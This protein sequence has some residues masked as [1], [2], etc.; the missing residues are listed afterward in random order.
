MR[1]TESVVTPGESGGDV[2]IE[3][4]R[5]WLRPL[6]PRDLDFF[7]ELHSDPEITRFVPTFTREQARERLAEIGRQWSERGHGLC[8]VQ[9]KETGELIGRCGLNHWEL[10]DEVE[11]GWTFRR[12]C[13][14]RGYATEAARAVV[15]WGFDRLDVDYFTAMIVHGNSASVRVAER[16]GFEPGRQ[17]T[18][19]GKPVTVHMLHRPGRHRARDADR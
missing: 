16:L 14:G 6:T 3:T 13:W 4:E 15:E 12:D 7:V 17:D 5:L 9:S 2:V 19:L 10:F 1:S 8:A 18:F 11:A